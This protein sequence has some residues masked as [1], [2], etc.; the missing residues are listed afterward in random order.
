[1]TTVF[2]SHASADKTQVDAIVG[3]LEKTDLQIRLDRHD[4][5][6]GM[7]FIRFM[8]D[9]LSTSD[10]CVLLWSEAAARSVYVTAEWE[11]ALD[12]SLAEA[13]AFLLVARLQAHPVPQL[14]RPRLY[15]DLFPE[16]E[17]GFTQLMKTLQADANVTTAVNKPTAAVAAHAVAS[18][19]AVEVYV[20]SELFD[21]A[22][23]VPIE[24]DQPVGVFLER[25]IKIWG[26]PNAI[27]HKERV[28]IAFQYSLRLNGIELE[29]HQRASLFG[30][31]HSD[32]LELI[33]TIVPMVPVEPE[34][35]AMTSARYKGWTAQKPE[36]EGYP[37]AL[38]VGRTLLLEAMTQS[39]LRRTKLL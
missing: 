15:V 13:R 38:A 36:A 26:L 12:R 2:V 27:D 29:R 23:P 11:A 32:V 33:T 21:I 28:R 5:S 8:E 30:L 16:P 37:Q 25:L 14:L 1:M 10:Y 31:V 4:I 3:L 19:R 20:V 22:V 39:R 9:A 34:S 17:P 24:L 6:T 35:G 18:A 7:S